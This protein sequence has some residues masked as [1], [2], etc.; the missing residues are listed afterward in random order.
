MRK[1]LLGLGM[2]LSLV[3]CS[4]SEKDR[5]GP[6][7]PNYKDGAMPD[8]ISNASEKQRPLWS[9]ELLKWKTEHGKD[10]L[11][12][13]VGSVEN[14]PNR[15]SAISEAKLEAMAEMS[16]QISVKVTESIYKTQTSYV[17]TDKEVTP[18]ELYEIVSRRIKSKND[19]LVQGVK[20]E[21]VFWWSKKANGGEVYDAWVLMSVTKD[22][23][24]K[25][26]AAA[27][28]KAMMKDQAALNKVLSDMKDKDSSKQE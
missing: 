16:N 13:A 15:N 1:I 10:T 8:N 6:N 23:M 18:S 28:R 4:S 21:D 2:A 27:A 25:S 14:R 17:V 24:Q 5:V 7:L 3:S 19:N 9:L 22:Q 12:Y 26:L 11:E 20:M